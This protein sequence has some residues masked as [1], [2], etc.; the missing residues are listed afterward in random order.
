MESFLD[1]LYHEEELK[2]DTD[3][4]VIVG[5]KNDKQQQEKSQITPARYTAISDELDLVSFL[6]IDNPLALI[7]PLNYFFAFKVK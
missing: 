5:N 4:N 3:N 1:D 6:P 7:F 2:K